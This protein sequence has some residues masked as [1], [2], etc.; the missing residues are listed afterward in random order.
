MNKDFEIGSRKFKLNKIG[1]FKQF[2]IVRR[3]APV[4]KD[5]IPLAM[6]Y[7]KMEKAGLSIESLSEEDTIGSLAPIV[8]GL[9]KL[10]DK[11]A[12]FVLMG[13]LCAVEMQQSAGNW[14]KVANENGLMFNDLDLPVLLQLA[15]RAFMYNVSGFFT[16]LPQ[17]SHG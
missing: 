13:L 5:M 1:A 2:H 16:A 3:L 9:S 10:D 15:G 14:A 17:V 12:D 11:E 4:L 8:D 7:Q 6:K